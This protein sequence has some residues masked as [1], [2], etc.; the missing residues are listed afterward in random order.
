M[1]LKKR[2]RDETL[3]D[4]SQERKWSFNF[5]NIFNFFK[6]ESGKEHS[7]KKQRTSNEI[8]NERNSIRKEDFVKK[9]RNASN[10]RRELSE[11]ISK[12]AVPRKS[13]IN[14]STGIYQ[15]YYDNLRNEN[16]SLYSKSDAR[17]ENSTAKGADKD[18][19]YS[20]SNNRDLVPIGDSQP[21]S[22]LNFSE[23]DQTVVRHDLS[24]NPID[25]NIWNN[26]LP[27]EDSFATVYLDENGDIARPPFINLDPRE[28]YQLLRLKKSI[29]T[30]NSLQDG[31]KYT[32]DPNETVSSISRDG[33]IETATQTHDMNYLQ[34][35]LNFIGMKRKTEE[36]LDGPIFKRAKNSHGYFSGTFFYDDVDDKVRRGSK[37][38]KG[39]LGKLKKPQFS[40]TKD[41]VESFSTK[42]NA[43]EYTLF[44]RFSD[45][46]RKT[47][48]ERSGLDQSL[49]SDEKVH[50]KLDPDYVKNNERISNLIKI[51]SDIPSKSTEATE[52][53]AAF[54]ISINPDEIK[55]IMEKDKSI[56]SSNLQAPSGVMKERGEA[57]SSQPTLSFKN[58]IAEKYTDA[59]KTVPFGATKDKNETSEKPSFPSNSL[60][61]I[62]SKTGE[63]PSFSFGKDQKSF[64]NQPEEK[65]TS[66]FEAKSQSAS[67]IP[68]GNL[69][70][71]KETTADTT[72]KP[73]F[74]FGSQKG[75]ADE[76]PALFGTSKESSSKEPFAKDK[77]ES[78]S[79]T[80][81]APS[82]GL[83]F[84]AA[85]QEAPKA[86]FTFGGIKPPSSSG[87]PD[88]TFGFSTENKSLQLSEEKPLF[89]FGT[90][91]DDKKEDNKED[92]KEGS[93]GTL[94]LK[95]DM[96]SAHM[97][98]RKK[99]SFAFDSQNLSQPFKLSTNNSST[100]SG[101]SPSISTENNNLSSN[102]QQ[103]QP[104]FTFGSA[105]E[106][107]AK[108]PSSLATVPASAH[109][110][111]APQATNKPLFTF[112]STSATS[113]QNPSPFTFGTLPNAPSQPKDT[114]VSQPELSLLANNQAVSQQQKSSLFGPVPSNPL[115]NF[116]LG[117]NFTGAPTFPGA[118]AS[119]GAPSQKPTFSFTGTLSKEASPDPSKIF[120]PVGIPTT[121]S[122]EHTP[123]AFNSS[124]R[125]FSPSVQQPLPFGNAANMNNNF[126]NGS[127]SFNS[128]APGSM[129]TPNFAT[130]SFNPQNPTSTP[131]ILRTNRKIA[132][133][134]QRRR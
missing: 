99:R 5:L 42:E 55:S 9:D 105:K 21:Y 53:S 40:D 20:A 48:K 49:L 26:E 124:Q 93:S 47:T 54:K 2:S 91:K 10:Q 39:Y 16:E 69:F 15:S 23:E 61:G 123:L 46:N 83:S 35:S 102:K 28:R 74:K 19:D 112:G 63:K 70:G 132:Q 84:Q 117:N 90:K 11:G 75:P 79:A 116:T 59:K 113:S 52:P 98:E 104:S 67:T 78:S 18:S 106:E 27:K 13:S 6:S 31:L 71:K 64:S 62:F 88:F 100:L 80:G 32:V 44:S 34:N 22:I 121:S 1:A 110:A 77:T 68:T 3:D 82:E 85:S 118:S 58:D 12:W 66:L 129:A 94:A 86:K 119:S 76:K 92:K 103:Q 45:H 87:K 37:S 134:R 60:D 108:I 33:K 65:K 56:P 95:T 89:S 126:A 57:T 8:E 97:P 115:F 101:T 81:A 131:P 130:P 29:E 25:G 50:L 120:G 41:K 128:A 30:S 114:A 109:A 51:K 24:S 4:A 125:L 122:R 73:I 111:S 38:F 14:N 127:Q 72:A 36:K 7:E 43:D 17:P 133:M 96:D 107:P